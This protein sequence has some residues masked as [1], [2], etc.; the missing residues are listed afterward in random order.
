[1][2]KI[3]K[4]I[5]KLT[6]VATLYYEEDKTQ[7]DI[8]KELN[9]SRPLISR[10]LKE[11]KEL[12]IVEV[13]I[14]TV[15][16]SFTV[17]NSQLIDR[18]DIQIGSIIAERENDAETNKQI[19]QEVI[20]FLAKKKEKILGIGW[21]TITGELVQLIQGKDLQIAKNI[22]PLLGNSNVSNKNYHSNE[23]VRLL[24]EKTGAKP[25]Y[26]H[27]PAFAET[28]QERDS[29]KA[30]DSFKKLEKSWDNMTVAV[31]NI[32]N[33]PSS[34]DFGSAAR[35]GNIL[36]KNNAV[37]RLLSY[38]YNEDGKILKSDADYAIQIPIDTLS[39]CS[40]VVGIC[41]ANITQSCLLG[42]LRTGLLTH[43]ICPETVLMK[44]LSVEEGKN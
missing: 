30:T 42:A 5:Q 35:Y 8:A 40:K 15:L 12:G 31:V 24:S 7:A 22:C 4:K 25:V 37:G 20:R 19:A 11:A 17:V 38:F 6:R 28:L 33:Y 39:Q 21:G 36:A 41:S 10:M 34:P 3:A 18:F 13:K 43:I 29:F 44:I 16:D 32:G 9:V 26:I 1:M 23:L 27:A 2:N 14:N